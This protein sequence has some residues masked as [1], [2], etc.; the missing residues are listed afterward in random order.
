MRPDQVGTHHQ[1][2]ETALRN[3][4][5]DSSA[6]LNAAKSAASLVRANASR[7]G[8]TVA[9]RVVSKSG[10]VRVTVTGPHASRYRQLMEREMDARMPDVHAEIRAQITR[11]AK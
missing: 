2:L 10:G 3:P 8:H 1:E 4:P 5:M 7:N 9:V 11:R 6:L